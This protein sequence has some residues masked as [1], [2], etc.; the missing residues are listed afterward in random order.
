MSFKEFLKEELFSG[1]VRIILSKTKLRV[2]CKF[3]KQECIPVGCVLSTA[4]AAGRGACIP[5]CTG[6]SGGVCLGGGLPQGVSLTACSDIFSANNT[7][8]IVYFPLHSFCVGNFPMSNELK[9]PQNLI[10]IRFA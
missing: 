9:S 4:V 6:Q 3:F 7:F 5:A 10:A 2:N 1:N 8:N